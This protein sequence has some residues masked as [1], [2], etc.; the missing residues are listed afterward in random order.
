MSLACDLAPAK[1]AAPSTIAPL[2]GHCD[3]ML[4]ESLMS[5]IARSCAASG[6]RNL[7]TVMSS[8]GITARTPFVPFTQVAAAEDIAA[9]LRVPS[10]EIAARM[11]P[12]SREVVDWYGT[13]MRRLFIEAVHR[14]YAP[15]SLRQSAHHR[16]AWGLRPLPFCPDS[17]ELLSSKC[18]V[19]GRVLGWD[20]T[21]GLDRCEHCLAAL[22]DCL[23]PKIDIP[24]RRDAA[25]IAAIVSVK[26]SERQRAMASLPAPF[27]TWAAGDVFEAILEFGV[28]LERLAEGAG[29]GG[30]ILLSS[31]RYD[32]IK[33]QT[34]LG[35]LRFID[36]WPDSFARFLDRVGSTSNAGASAALGPCL[37]PLGKFARGYQAI[38]PLS[39]VIAAE[40]ATALRAARVPVKS[41]ALNRVAPHSDD[42]L[43][44]EKEA[45]EAFDIYQ[46]HLRRLDVSSPTL[47]M[48]RA[49]VTKLY[50][51][52]CLARSISLFRS[53][54]LHADARAVIGIPDYCWPALASHGLIV[55]ENDRDAVM[56]SGH[57]CLVTKRSL[58]EIRNRLPGKVISSKDRLIT[59]NKAMRH[60]LAPDAWAVA[61]TFA[62]SNGVD[63][64]PEDADL[65]SRLLVDP[66]ELFT[67]LS[68]RVWAIPAGVRVSCIT[69]GKLI[70]QA[71]VLIGK[72]L[73]EGLINGVVGF[74]RHAV[75]LHEL[76]QFSQNYMVTNEIA[77]RLGCTTRTAGTILR[78][79]GVQPACMVYRMAVWNR[80]EAERSQ[81]LAPS[82]QHALVQHLADV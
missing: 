4:G 71:D 35:G 55:L 56:M 20:R 81:G 28:A 69:A 42:G 39:E 34:V 29:G 31:G 41:T 13:P 19:C 17:F 23:S 66:V 1:E 5:L 65:A 44:S 15:E 75:E 80:A 57:D 51:R 76:R 12:G 27:C 8:I 7:A 2:L 78:E 49:S 38:S 68:K 62:L 18:P 73:T 79:A 64:G 11:H 14:R 67:E 46:T 10:H 47:V 16:A 26:E 3:P 9:L 53:G 24:D 22:T 45:L 50:N 70:G 37:G 52:E 30:V 59:L 77:D 40:A 72:A 63:A 6:F 33:P 48:Q 82:L 21:R 54:A 32:D 61:L 60:V 43:I 74:R 25:R 58:S 36:G